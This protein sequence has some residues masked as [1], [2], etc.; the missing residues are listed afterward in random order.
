[1]ENLW[2]KLIGILEEENILYKD[3]LAL[4]RHKT[5]T[6]V[7]GKVS[8]LEQLTKVEQRMMISIGNLEQQREA[9]VEGL[10][11]H[12][13]IPAEE[14]NISLAVEQVGEGLGNRLNVL[15]LE[16]SE[17]LKELKKV[18]DL[19][20]QL[21]ERS[22]EYID[23]SMNLIAGNSSEV[24]YSAKK[25]GDKGKGGSLFDYKA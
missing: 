17:I 22:L 10:T 9:A 11:R 3:I 21:I 4:S 24:T 23:F 8:E 13:N 2:E 20:S 14:L 19:N 1:M 15:K 6:I 7:E 5:G 16:I 25:G 12:L 18:N